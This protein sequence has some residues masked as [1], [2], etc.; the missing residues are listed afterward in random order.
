MVSAILAVLSIAQG[1]STAD[2]TGKFDAARAFGLLKAQCD[3]GVRAP[4]TPGHAKCL[5]WIQEQ[6]KPFVDRVTLQPFRH[7]WSQN[8]EI[9][10]MN[11]VLATV[12]WE[13]AKVRVILMAHWDTR[14]TADMERSSAKQRQPILGANDGASGVAVLLELMRVL[15]GRH[16]DV[17]I[18]YA[19][20]D[21]EDLGPD[22][23]EMFLGAR[24]L[25]RNLPEPRPQYGIL[26][27]MVGDKNLRIPKEAYSNYYA[28]S[29]MKE[30]YLHARRLDLQ[31]TFPNVEGQPIMDDHLELNKV[32]VPTVD[33]IDFDYPYWHTLDDTPDKCSAES[34]GKVGKLL[35]SW[36]TRSPVWTLER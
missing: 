10:A 33:L 23:D 35:E 20:V 14:P 12:N 21:G 8:G 15:K 11:N 3:I 18:V 1:P 25:A 17:G 30:L 36:F 9:I 13:N 32:G 34:L 28:P 4:D 6:A 5:A 19:F 7:T 31:A 27:D 22:V 26:L 24:H 16:P 29:L 2:A